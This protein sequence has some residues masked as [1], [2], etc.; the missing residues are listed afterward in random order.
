[1]FD[2]G[3]LRWSWVTWALVT[4]MATPYIYFAGNILLHFTFYAY[5]IFYYMLYIYSN[6]RLLTF[7]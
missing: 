4:S 3:D 2:T 1:M 5:Y 7:I 6:L